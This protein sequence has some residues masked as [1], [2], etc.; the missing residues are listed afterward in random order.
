M[1]DQP[2]VSGVDLARVALQ[3]ARASAKAA[4]PPK[5]RTGAAPPRGARSGGRGPMGLGAAIGRMVT[6]RGW[7]QATAGGSLL[8]QWPTIAPALAGHVTAVR[9]DT[10]TR[11]LHLLPATAAY[12][13]QLAL[14]QRDII[15]K[16]NAAAGPDAV[17]Q[18]EILRPADLDARSVPLPTPQSAPAVAP[19][20]VRSQGEAPVKTREDASDGYNQALAAHRAARDT[21][22][23]SRPSP[24]VQAAAERQ[25]R[26]AREPEE[27]FG[28][29]CKAIEGL[30]HKVAVQQRAATSSNAARARALQRL[31][32]ERAGRGA[33]PT[34]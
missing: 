25:I 9:Y 15:A 5:R 33:W 21:R 31:A 3:A 16:V 2:P 7:E 14:H 8:A 11:T 17:R 18:L 1:T 23:N 22:T 27:L 26:E 24:L 32:A 4:P 30:R 13:T 20:E 12:R 34:A 10:E 6:D 29:G 19:L 28:D